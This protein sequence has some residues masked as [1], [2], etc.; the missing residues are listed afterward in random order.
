M[1][2]FPAGPLEQAGDF[3]QKIRS[4]RAAAA[5]SVAEFKHLLETQELT[6]DASAEEM[7]QQQ[8]SLLEADLMSAE[9]TPKGRTLGSPHT[10]EPTPRPRSGE[11]GELAAAVDTEVAVEEAPGAGVSAGEPLA[12]LQQKLADA[13]PELAATMAELP[14]SR[15][16][17][18][19]AKKELDSMYMLQLDLQADVQGVQAC[20]AQL[21]QQLEAAQ[22]GHVAAMQHGQGLQQHVQGLEQQ[23]QLAQQQAHAYKQQLQQV[24]AD[25]QQAHRPLQQLQAESQQVEQTHQADKHELQEAAELSQQRQQHLQQEVQLQKHQLL[26]SQQQ[27]QQL[28]GELEQQ[29]Q[30]KQ[31]REQAQEQQQQTEQRL[32][33]EVELQKT[34]L[35]LSQQQVQQLQS[36][37]EQ[38]TQQCQQAQEHAQQAEQQLQHLQ[39]E[40]KLQK[41][42]LTLSYQEL[43]HLQG[44][45]EQQK[46]QGQQ[47]QQAEQLLRQEVELQKEQLL[48]SQQQLEQLQGEVQLQQQQ[49]QQ[50]TQQ[51]QQAEQRLQQLQQVAELLQ[52]Q[53]QQAQEQ[54]EQQLHQASL[55]LQQNSEHLQQLQE[56]TKSLS[57]QLDSATEEAQLQQSRMMEQLQQAQQD[58][59]LKGQQLQQAQQ[60]AQS[61]AQQVQQAQQGMQSASQQLQQAQKEA[62]QKGQQV[63]EAQECAQ[64]QQQLLQQAQQELAAAQQQLRQTEAE[65]ADLKRQ[66]I[67]AQADTQDAQLLLESTTGAVAAARQQL[68]HVAAAKL[69][70]QAGLIEALR[71]GEVSTEQLAV[72]AEQA[73]VLQQKHLHQQDASD[74]RLQQQQLQLTHAEA[75]AADQAELLQVL[76]QRLTSLEAQYASWQTA[77]ARVDDVKQQLPAAQAAALSYQ[78]QLAAA[79]AELQAQQLAAEAAN[80]EHQQHL[81][82]LQVQ[83]ETTETQLSEAEQQ[84]QGLQAAAHTRLGMLEELQAQL[85]QAQQQVQDRDHS[86]M[87]ELLSPPGLQGQQRQTASVDAPA[88]PPLQQLPVQG[89]SFPP[90]FGLE[91]NL[92]NS[93]GVSQ[94]PADQTLLPNHRPRLPTHNSSISGAQADLTGLT[95][96]LPWL[97]QQGV[98]P[99]VAEGPASSLLAELQHES[100]ELTEQLTQLQ[101]YLKT[102]TVKYADLHT[103]EVMDE[104]L[105][106]LR[107]LTSEV[108]GVASE[109]VQRVTTAG[110]APQSAPTSFAGRAPSRA[111]TA[112]KYASCAGVFEGSIGLQSESEQSAVSSGVSPV[113]PSSAASRSVALRRLGV[114]LPRLQSWGSEAA[115]PDT[116]LQHSVAGDTGNNPL[117]TGGPLSA[118]AASS[119]G[120][121][122]NVAMVGDVLTQPPASGLQALAIRLD[123]WG[124]DLSEAPCSWLIGDAPLPACCAEELATGAVEPTHSSLSCF[125][126]PSGATAAAA[127]AARVPSRL[128]AVT[129]ATVGEPGMLSAW[130]SGMLPVSGPGAA[131]LDQQQQQQQQ[132]QGAGVDTLHHLLHSRVVGSSA[133]SLRDQLQAALA[134]VQQLHGERLVLRSQVV[135][136]AEL[137]AQQE[138]R[139]AV[140][141][142]LL[143]A[144]AT[145]WLEGE[146][147][148]G[149]VAMGL[150]Q[151]TPAVA[152]DVACTASRQ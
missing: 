94:H 9:V 136:L 2:V 13:R 36:E 132:Q 29:K 38:Q 66:L 84:V 56:E 143:S 93:T 35:T 32:Q 72:A 52:Q 98:W 63:T 34:Q 120:G 82:Q 110:A 103:I 41:E 67:K 19:T 14:Q 46:Q 138:D 79:Q 54:V 96:Q 126:S 73:Q 48:L 28:Q 22:Q 58:A 133:G 129:I 90:P 113:L 116:P 97:S 114:E 24:Q 8:L 1:P 33:Q 151:A 6:E 142:E 77:Q 150:T 10:Q 117:A 139:L 60:D 27:M 61:M 86:P 152:L 57:K 106:V 85:A 31:Q 20:I 134:E 112:H 88:V 81:D 123:H 17:L 125:A 146:E 141:D 40:A 92:V 78:Q 15:A 111:G 4:A 18:A 21:T 89:R 64:R 7:L 80:Q 149:W 30:Q 100:D 115:L 122:H 50:A 75:A 37:L 53:W 44:D 95:S 144:L 147:D 68:Q 59:L 23:L 102:S 87:A 42:Q 99:L 39:Q 47:A 71:D 70:L 131:V 121:G 135:Q 148:E 16:Q 45:L 25:V 26:L 119:L 69:A 104:G 101:Q 43:Q 3:I 130:G 91:Q 55:K 137:A 12:L 124:S 11:G 127:A 83:L 5:T 108:V 74:K 105:Q 107:R 62:A 118:A 145:G 140:N 49:R 76:Q 109:T 51:A 128:A 65:A